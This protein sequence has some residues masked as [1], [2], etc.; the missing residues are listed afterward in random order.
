[1]DI[2]IFYWSAENGTSELDY[3]V[4][5]GSNNIPI[6][7]KANENL[8]AKSLKSFI[9]KYDTKINVRTYMANY[10]KEELLI[11]IPL[12]MIGDIEEILK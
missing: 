9:N 10:R 1:M 8:Q 4:Q 11:N 3:I 7:V 5:I 6:E 2:P 12:Y